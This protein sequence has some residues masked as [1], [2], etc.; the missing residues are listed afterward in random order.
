MCLLVF[1]HNFISSS[2]KHHGRGII[3]INIAILQMKKPGELSD[4]Y[5]PR[6]RKGKRQDSNLGLTTQKPALSTLCPTATG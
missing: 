1:M 3:V 6:A 5:K 2:K 4:L